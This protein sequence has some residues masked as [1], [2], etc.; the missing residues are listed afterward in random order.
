MNKKDPKLVALQFNDCINARDLDGLTAFMTDDHTFID[1]VNKEH[2]GK[3]TMT[4]GWQEFFRRYPDY[5]NIFTTVC[6]RDNRVIMIGYSTCS[7]E[8]KLG[9]PALWTA[10]IENDLVAEWRVYD[11]TEDNRNKLGVKL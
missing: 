1:S 10:I 3:A 9:G 8:P 7:N 11:D 4:K 5:K 6:S 2:R